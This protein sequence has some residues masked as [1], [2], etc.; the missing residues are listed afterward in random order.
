MLDCGDKYTT[1][2]L[3]EK[4]LETVVSKDD[5]LYKTTE[6]TKKGNKTVYV[7]KG[8]YVKNYIKIGKVKFRIIKIDSSGNLVLIEN[9]YDDDVDYRVGWDNRYNVNKDGNYGIGEYY[10]SIIRKRVTERVY[11]ALSDSIKEKLVLKDICI[12]SRGETDTVKD[13]SIECKTTLGNDYISLLTVYDFMNASL[14]PNCKITISR[15]CENYNYLNK[16]DEPFWLLNVSSANTYTGY[17]VNGYISTARLS[18]SAVARIVLTAT[19]NLVYAG[20]SGTS[21]DPYIVK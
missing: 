12:G 2:Y 21:S 20:G 19:K 16:Y 6:Y 10:K 8:D 14:D 7:Y 5:G 15:S 9:S 3:N 18:S 11:V 13:G 1:R 4:L 17:M